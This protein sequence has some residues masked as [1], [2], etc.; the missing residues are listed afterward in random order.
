MN[1]RRLTPLRLSVLAYVLY[2]VHA[3]L[4]IWAALFGLWP[5]FLPSTLATLSGFVL[6]VLGVLPYGAGAADMRSFA[7]MSGRRADQLITSGAYRFSRHPQLVGWASV[8]L[9]RSWLAL[10]LALVYLVAT[11]TLITPAEECKLVALYRQAY[12][13]Y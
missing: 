12:R 5:S 10:L 13:D 3:P 4:V 2:S 11:T 7:R 9:G 1:D 6:I 8:L